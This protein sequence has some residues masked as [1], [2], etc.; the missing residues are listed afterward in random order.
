M[1]MKKFDCITFGSATQDI[2]FYTD[3][4]MIVRN[5]KDVTRQKLIAFEYGAKLNAQAIHFTLGGGANNVAVALSKLGLKTALV[6]AI[7]D[8]GLGRE[9]VANIRAHKIYDGLVQTVAGERSR[10]SLIVNTGK[11]NEHVAFVSSGANTKLKVTQAGLGRI[12]SQWYYVASL[13]GEGWKAN[14]KNIF[15]QAAKTKTKVAWNPGGTQLELGY[16]YLRK[17]IRQTEVL[18]LNQDEAIELVLSYGKRVTDVEKLLMIIKSWGIGVVVITCAY[19]GAYAFD[20]KKM[21]YHKAMKVKP[22]NT[23]GAGDSFGS[24]FLWGVFKLRSYDQALQAGI[25]NSNSVI[26]EIG[27]QNGLLSLRQLKNKL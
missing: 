19:K 23:T 7:G 15:T 11:F 22:I 26:T 9:I 14:L 20:G 10:F 2:M 3:E 17:Y 8:D 1:T 12:R 18:F 24:A 13:Q 6:T 16:I 25:L 21:Y 27:A 4:T 5:A